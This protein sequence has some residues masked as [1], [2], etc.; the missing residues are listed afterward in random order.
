MA[1]RAHVTYAK[2]RMAR[3][4]G[5]DL[6]AEMPWLDRSRVSASGAAFSLSDTVSQ[7][8]FRESVLREVTRDSTLDVARMNPRSGERLS[9]SVMRH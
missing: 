6:P 9:V 3:G 1:A 8:C 5:K 2:T 4:S 7:E